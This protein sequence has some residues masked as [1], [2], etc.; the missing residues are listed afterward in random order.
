MGLL[1]AFLAAELPTVLQNAIHAATAGLRVPL[2]NNV[3]RWVP[4]QNIHL[5][6]KFLGDVAPSGLDLIKQML[7]TEASQFAAF[8]VRVEGLGCYPSPRQPRVL[9]VGLIAP[10]DLASL[11]RAI[12]TAA[13]RLGYEAEE[14]SFSPHL[15]IGR[16]RQNAAAADVHGIRIALDSTRVGVLGSARVDA[17]HLFKSE[18]RPEGS[19]YTKLFSAP[20]RES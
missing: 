18:L 8:D 15:T 12:E 6:L 17:I 3:I 9:W 10:P 1:R 2:G 7:L 13:A 11:Q 16:V 19:A 4:P 14:R 5:T 20:L